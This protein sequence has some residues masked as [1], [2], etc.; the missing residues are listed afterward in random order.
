M[1]RGLGVRIGA[2]VACACLPLAL[3][4]AGGCARSPEPEASR[5]PG[6]AG[7]LALAVHVFAD[8]GRGGR[9]EVRP[10]GARVWLA[11]V[12][13]TRGAMPSPALPEATP[14]SLPPPDEAPPGLAVD[15]GLKPPVLRA[16]GTL[17]LPPGWHG[18]RV[19]VELDVRV[20]ES[21]RVSDVF[22]AVVGS[23]SS[24]LDA[25]LVEA[26]RRCALGMRFYPALQAGRPVP[27]WC[28]QRFDFGGTPR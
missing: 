26:A 11:S 14:D 6:R 16:P 17:A 4:I 15:S 23:D 3:L 13:P 18:P 9:L 19:S 22:A 25:G 28:R 21:G 7:A 27:V 12:A 2:R 5:P 10:P 1:P 20:D 24:G 8:T